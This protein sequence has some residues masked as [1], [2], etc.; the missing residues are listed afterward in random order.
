[1]KTLT[2][3]ALL[4]AVMALTTAVSVPLVIGSSTCC[5][6]GWR[7]INGRCFLFV[8]RAMSWAHAERNCLSMGAN[9]A[10]VHGALEQ[11]EIQR[12]VR[13][14][15]HGH[16]DT[17]IGGSDAEMEGVWL[18]SDGT[19]YTFTN[20]CRGEPNNLGKEHCAELNFRGKK[21]WNDRRCNHNIASVCAKNI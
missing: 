21:C 12:M 4:C 1:M 11:D 5:P 8:R 15:T 18:W 9:L 14:V 19:P 10:S 7:M 6:D 3:T 2:V 20:W 13:D 17:W 16:P